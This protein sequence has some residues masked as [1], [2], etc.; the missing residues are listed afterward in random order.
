MLKRIFLLSAT[1]ILLASSNASAAV[2]NP[3][4]QC[5]NAVKAKSYG[6]ARN[7]GLAAVKATPKNFNARLCLGIAEDRLGLYKEAM[8]DLKLAVP[9]AQK[10][11]GL[12]ISYS[13]MGKTAQNM[14]KLNKALDY[15]LKSL[16]I[17]VKLKNINFEMAEYNN[18]AGI[19]IIEKKFK[20][21]LGYL[22]KILS[23]SAAGQSKAAAYSNIGL[24]YAKIGNYG[25]ALKF[26]KTAL[27]INEK[28]KSDYGIGENFLNIGVSYLHMKKYAQAKRYILRGLSIEKKIS[29]KVWTGTGYGYLANLY[30][31]EDKDKK[32]AYY[33]KKAYLLYKASGDVLGAKVCA[34]MIKKIKERPETVSLEKCI[35]DFN[36][37]DYKLSLASCRQAADNYP[38]NFF[39][40]FFYAKSYMGIKNY[41]MALKEFKKTL[42]LTAG[43]INKRQLIYNWIG[44]SYAGM[45]NYGEA[46]L[47]LKKA[48]SLSEKIKSRKDMISN[49]TLLKEISFKEKKYE[50]D[51]NYSK[52]Y[53]SLLKGRKYIAMEDDE[54][55]VIYYNIG[56]YNKSVEY[57][58]KAL[59]IDSDIKN[60]DGASLDI[61][62]LCHSLI[63]LKK[64]NK[65]KVYIIKGIKFAK[66]AKDGYKTALG[67][68]TL[69]YYYESAKNGSKAEISYMKAYRLYKKLKDV[70]YAKYCLFK[71]DKLKKAGQ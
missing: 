4:D 58:K 7:Y 35:G 63:K 69:G 38:S 14:G 49:L 34:L 28:L 68:L 53:L 20:K 59:A 46:V 16:D 39:A 47:F 51:L 42:P 19:Y 71:A 25:K 62:N 2:T 18:I 67:Y 22:Y 36:K 9:L 44:G 65:V 10:K 23:L 37:N 6:S 15:D 29:D 43:D 66:L 40:K 3:L 52:Q 33:Y 21:S 56:K 27:S 17:S 41:S 31:R 5:L 57:D 64:E 8:N 70:Y 50:D 61:F 60:Y 24:I 54:I 30:F 13:L 55:G 45:K 1:V 26:Q 11:I 48:L 12:A 32:S